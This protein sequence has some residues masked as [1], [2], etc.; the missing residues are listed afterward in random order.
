M[1][2]ERFD[3]AASEWDGKSRRVQLAK[4][5]SN[6]ISKLALTKEMDAM[7]YGCGTGLVGIAISPAIKKLTAIDTSPG[8]LEVL[9]Q[10]I[11]TEALENIR[12]LRCDL[13][14]E[15]YTTM[16][17]L[18]LCSMTLHHIE[19]ARGLLQ[20]FAEFLLPGGYIAIAD[21]FSEDGTFHDADAEGIHHNGFDPE[22]LKAVLNSCGLEDISH[23]TVHTIAKADN[24]REY[25]VFLLTARKPS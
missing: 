4:K 8:M 6:A 15:D 22:E 11:S 17:H 20:R 9:E 21:L 18:I 25:P 13:L 12:T 23:T 16:H 24:N 7:E 2:T 19:D 1:S 3:K 14:A 10:K 5:I